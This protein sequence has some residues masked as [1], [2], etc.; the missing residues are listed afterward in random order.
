MPDA[1]GIDGYLVGL[2][3]NP[4]TM[5]TKLPEGIP[6]DARYLLLNITIPILYYTS[7]N[8]PS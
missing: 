5:F 6:N 1:A 2:Y 4:F 8:N 7:L 3:A